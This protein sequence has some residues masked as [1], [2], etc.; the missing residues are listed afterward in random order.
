MDEDDTTPCPNCDTLEHSLAVQRDLAR[1]QG[2][3]LQRAKAERDKLR[4][5]LVNAGE[6]WTR[7]MGERDKATAD[8][9]AVAQHRDRLECERHD[10]ITERDAAKK[11]AAEWSAL[12]WSVREDLVITRATVATLTTR[13]RIAWGVIG[14]LC[15]ALGVV[16]VVG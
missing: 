3:R 4:G 11:E 16:G 13:L 9:L 8:L 1:G 7:C 12:S 6:S 2:V 10:A 5:K 14:L 15:V